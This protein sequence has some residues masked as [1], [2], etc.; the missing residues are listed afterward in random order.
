M[1]Q[2]ETE[3]KLVD[4]LRRKAQQ[5]LQTPGVTSVG[6]GYKIK[7]GKPTDQLSIQ[8]TVKQKK[9]PSALEAE[10]VTKLPES[11][12]DD[13]GTVVPVDVLQRSYQPSVMVLSRPEKASGR[14]QR[15][16]R[17]DPIMPGISV[18]HRDESAG[19]IGAIVFDAD[20]AEPCILSNW[21]VLHGP[22]GEPGDAVLQPGPFD[23]GSLERSRAGKLIRSHLGLAGDCALASIEG[24]RFDQA[25]Y[26]LGVAPARIGLVNLNDRVVKSGRTTGVTH[27]IVRRVGVVVR[28][29]YG[30]AI[31]EREIGGFEIG[32]NPDRPAPGGEISSG[33][34]SGSC[35][36]SDDADHRDVLVGLHLAG[37][38]DPDPAAEH[39]LA[40][41]IHSV[42]DKLNVALQPPV[43]PRTDGTR[44]VGV[45]GRGEPGAREAEEVPEDLPALNLDS[46]AE[47]ERFLD[48]DPEQAVAA[49]RN[50]FGQ[51]FTE[52]QIRVS[53]AAARAALE[54]PG[55]LLPV[56]EARAS[57]EDL[58]APLP[59]DFT[60]P[61]M[62]LNEIPIN[63]DD[64]RFEEVA[65]ALGWAIFAGPGVLRERLGLGEADFRD[66]EKHD[67]RFTYKLDEP[68]PEHPLE[69]ALFSDFG[70]GRYHSLYIARQFRERRFPCAIHLG[71]VY[72]AG[73][74]SE[75]RDYIQAPLG[76]IL[77]HTQLF[78]LNSNH[79]MYS[80]GKWY[81]QFLDDKRA[82]HP[83]RQRQEGSYFALESVRFLIA[84]I[85]TAHDKQGRF[86]KDE[87][88]EWLRKKLS[89]AKAAGKTTIL[90]SADHPY[91]YGEGGL[92]D[93]A[94]DLRQILNQDL[95]DL[96]FW[97]NTHYC[98]L[99]DR[100]AAA[101]FIGSCIGH[102]GFPYVRKRSG[103]VEPAPM[104]FLE[105]AARF[106]E[107]TRLRQDMGNNGYC[108]LTLRHDGG[109]GL[110]YVDWMANVRHT[111][112]LAR[113][114][115]SGPLAFVR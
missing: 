3:R 80:G 65:D 52:Q 21:H 8:F 110:K 81:F 24:R 78:L 107:K 23:G 101:P 4:L 83:E 114:G 20:T 38:T 86:R 87:L 73:R 10:G 103:G 94:G 67:S 99:F 76:P 113:G 59:P 95:V 66:A 50:A 53:L 45:L 92:T 115:P 88:K 56:L 33:G 68:S 22:A 104:R 84:G 34:D 48:L 6:I 31:G 69:I 25:V 1:T 35:W 28:L 36:L 18:A 51:G 96:W 98:A 13:D 79:E 109:V 106:P 39:A 93:L 32:P 44:L 27:G 55:R 43:Q 30:G 91:E 97:G 14:L 108:V 60:F 26:E 57:L 62:D 64:R 9:S 90:L 77:D 11:I 102:G 63:P 82:G 40:C 105:T 71:D 89:G 41:N 42:F 58:K 12:V 100:G 19:T 75:F 37:E 47:L 85:D 72:Y 61:G 49:L 5:L 2:Q 15:R 74:K 54:R 16:R 70:T 29:D 17:L 112:T 111:E 7:D 46:L